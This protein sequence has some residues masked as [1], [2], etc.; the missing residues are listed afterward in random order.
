M[1]ILKIKLAVSRSKSEKLFESSQFCGY[2]ALSYDFI[3]IHKCSV[4]KLIEGDN[5][6]KVQIGL[7]AHDAKLICAAQILRFNGRFEIQ[8][9]PKSIKI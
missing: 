9:A 4:V 6:T 1:G 3:I 5:D 7:W 2:K 8:V